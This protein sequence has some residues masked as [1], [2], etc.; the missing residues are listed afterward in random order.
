[1]RE[2]LSHSGLDPVVCDF[3]LDQLANPTEDLNLIVKSIGGKGAGVAVKNDDFPFLIES[4]KS[5]AVLAGGAPY[6]GWAPA[7]IATLVILLYTFRKKG[8]SISANQ[9]VLL[10]ELKRHPGITARELADLLDQPEPEVLS[11]LQGLGSVRRRDGKNEALVAAD[12][13]GKWQVQDL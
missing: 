9:V 10:K 13:G 1:M 11:E 4:A 12:A 7:A 6:G 8:Y 5:V 3:V 2:E